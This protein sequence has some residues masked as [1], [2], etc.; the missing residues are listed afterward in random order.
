MITAAHASDAVDQ[1]PAYL[2]S[3]MVTSQPSPD[4]LLFLHPETRYPT[5]SITMDTR[6]ISQ[7]ALKLEN[8]DWANDAPNVPPFEDLVPPIQVGNEEGFSVSSLLPLSTPFVGFAVNGGITNFLVDEFEHPWT[9][10]KFKLPSTGGV[11][12]WRGTDEPSRLGKTL[13]PTIL[14]LYLHLED[15]ATAVPVAP[16]QQDVKTKFRN[17]LNRLVP[18]NRDYGNLL[19][20]LTFKTAISRK[21]TLMDGTLAPVMEGLPWQTPEDSAIMVA[22]VVAAVFAVKY[23]TAEHAYKQRLLGNI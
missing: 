17:F 21:K 12:E 16:G 22:S 20:C 2:P 9:I 23:R 1:P 4:L 15:Y 11:Y 8:E 13:I 3:E 18:K 7:V 14:T 10:L 6:R 19:P 5:Y